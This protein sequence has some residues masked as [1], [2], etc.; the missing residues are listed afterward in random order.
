MPLLRDDYARSTK[1]IFALLIM[2][3]IA[4]PLMR[5][6][7]AMMPAAAM[8]IR[9]DVAARGAAIIAAAYAADASLIRCRAIR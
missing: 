8:L 1:V 2:P 5:H 7:A 3:L 9:A 4:P 6:A